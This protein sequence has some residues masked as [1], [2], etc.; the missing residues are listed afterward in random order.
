MGSQL[1]IQVRFG[2]ELNESLNTVRFKHQSVQLEQKQFELLL[3]LLDSANQLVNKED[4]HRHVWQQTV[5]SDSALS[6]NIGAL[7]RAFEALEIPHLSLSVKAKKG[8][9]LHVSPSDGDGCTDIV[10]QTTSQTSA[11][12]TNRRFNIWRT[13]I[14][15]V[16]LLI[17][18]GVVTHLLEFDGHSNPSL[19]MHTESVTN[20]T[21]SNTNIALDSNDNVSFIQHDY[22]VTY[23]NSSKGFSTIIRQGNTIE[24]YRIKGW[25][26][27]FVW[28]KNYLA[29]HR[30]L[31]NQCSIYLIHLTA[32]NDSI[33]IPCQD[34]AGGS[35]MA[36]LS[37]DTLIFS[38]GEGATNYLYTV[39]LVEQSMRKSIATPNHVRDIYSIHVSPQQDKIAFLATTVEGRIS[40]FMGENNSLTEFSEIRVNTIP[41]TIQW[42]NNQI[43]AYIDTKNA[44][45]VTHN[46]HSSEIRNY[47]LGDKRLSGYF[48]VNDDNI[49]VSYITGQ[50]QNY[51]IINQFNVR[52]P[53]LSF[54]T[55]LHLASLKNESMHF[56]EQ[57]AGVENIW[58]KDDIG[59][60]QVTFYNQKNSIVDYKIGD[61]SVV[62]ATE[63]SVDI[64]EDSALVKSY[65]YAVDRIVQ[66][67]GLTTPFVLKDG[68][69]MRFNDTSIDIHIARV[70]S[71]FEANGYLWLTFTDKPG[72]YLRNNYLSND[73]VQS[74]HSE[75]TCGGI[76]S[77]IKYVDDDGLYC[78]I[79]DGS[80][81]LVY[82]DFL[83][84]TESLIETDGQVIAVHNDHILTKTMD[85]QIV[86][87]GIFSM[88]KLD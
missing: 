63:T 59:L 64:W 12:K 10:P 40:L 86:Y 31:D 14:G 50:Q 88:P 35:A 76:Y 32:D 57:N 68:N 43:V 78:L 36:L 28:T 49:L 51:S 53:E 74:L 1:A 82:I 39:D 69:L 16:L 15:I 46:Y 85:T 5:V 81:S 25:V 20:Q 8:Y 18:I 4:I 27:S 30:L 42:L 56:V 67:T 33:S 65:P 37:D 3:Y 79:R 80:E 6:R 2:V 71:A 22:G 9:I 84:K 60:I 45:L 75:N 47:T 87:L 54:S 13:V 52:L 34:H 26:S 83:T 19:T 44:L 48:A 23:S 61:A 77:H 72:L 24:R 62:V 29:A 73:G 21:V 58:A 7:R 38:D 70:A 55:S 41:K 66:S 17:V 11:I